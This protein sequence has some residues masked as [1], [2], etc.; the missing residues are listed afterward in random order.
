LF[1]GNLGS[2]TTELLWATEDANV[3]FKL[4]EKSPNPL[5]EDSELSANPPK[6][7]AAAGFSVTRPDWLSPDSTAPVAPN[8]NIP[9]FKVSAEAVELLEDP[10]PLVPNPDADG[11]LLNPLP[12]TPLAPESRPTERAED[13]VESPKPIPEEGAENPKLSFTSLVFFS[14]AVSAEEFPAGVPKGPKGFGV[15]PDSVCFA[16]VFEE[17]DE[18]PNAPHPIELVE[19]GGI[20]A[21]DGRSP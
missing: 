3:D 13:C 1:P 5:L 8:L 17:S 7:A 14:G 20:G 4:L 12:L 18:F 15:T 16:P 19:T 10:N 2:T 21:L 6:I 11:K 9:T